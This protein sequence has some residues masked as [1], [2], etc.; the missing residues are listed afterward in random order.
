MKEL[1]YVG[2]GSAFGGMLRYVISMLMKWDGSG[3]PWATFI[4][5]IVG[6]F[7]IGIFASILPRTPYPTSHLL[8][9]TGFCGGFTTFS[10]F[11]REALTL[12]HAEAYSAVLF[13]VVGSVALGLTAT[14]FG[15][16]LLK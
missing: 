16:M 13:Y 6:C 12:W 9:V 15:Y 8:W 2:I 11:S 5:N 14:L 10:T 4:V 7:L 3:F 1:L